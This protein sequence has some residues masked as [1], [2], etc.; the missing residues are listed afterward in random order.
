[1]KLEQNATY[2]AEVHV[3][4][5]LASDATVKEKLEDVGF[6]DVTVWDGRDGRMCRGVWPGLTTNEVAIPSA[7]RNIVRL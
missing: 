4:H 5:I 6:T 7:L 2:T 3:S 1:M